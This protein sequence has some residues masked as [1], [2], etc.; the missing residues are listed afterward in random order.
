[1]QKK[2]VLMFLA[3]GE[4]EKRVYTSDPTKKEKMVHKTEERPTLMPKAAG[5][6]WRVTVWQ[7]G[8]KSLIPLRVKK[9]S[10]SCEEGLCPFHLPLRERRSLTEG[11]K[12]KGGI[13]S[14]SKGRK[15]EQSADRV[16]K[17]R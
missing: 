12:G 6:G 10:T 2:K 13:R 5:R 8:G 14:V 1:L 16:G 3:S 4:G 11:N 15:E 9:G 7:A 17:K